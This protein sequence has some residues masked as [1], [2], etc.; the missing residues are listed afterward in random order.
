MASLNFVHIIAE[1]RS[2]S[3]ALFEYLNHNRPLNLALLEPL[4]NTTTNT[5]MATAIRHHTD[6]HHKIYNYEQLCVELETNASKY[7]VMKNLL[8]DLLKIPQPLQQRFWQLPGINLGLARR[9]LFE[10]TCS[11]LIANISGTTSSWN[12]HTAR[13]TFTID[14][15]IFMQALD[16]HLGLKQRWCNHRHQF[17]QTV[18]YE[19]IVWSSELHMTKNPPKHHHIINIDQLREWYVEWQ[20]SRAEGLQQICFELEI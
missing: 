12:G 20:Q 5:S 19:D 13:G 17:D 8:D 1:P 9:N 10:Q 15:P 18:F 7:K 6:R 3:T 2:G 16:H 4:E 14:G 11:N